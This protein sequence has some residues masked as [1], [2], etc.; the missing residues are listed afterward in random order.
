[1]NRVAW[2]EKNAGGRPHEVGTKTP[3]AWGLYDMLGNAAEWVRDCEH[4]Y[5]DAD[6]DVDPLWT[7]S[8]FWRRG[9]S[10]EHAGWDV[11]SGSRNWAHGG[12]GNDGNKWT[13]FRVMCRVGE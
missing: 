9:G 5:T 13:S 4:I 11:N 8:E 12:W 3:N 7:G 2:S 10:Y 1:M 6:D